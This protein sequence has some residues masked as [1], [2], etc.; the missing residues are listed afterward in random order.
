MFF[1]SVFSVS[2]SNEIRLLTKGSCIYAAI[3]QHILFLS[4][5]TWVL[6]KNV[7]SKECGCL[8]CNMNVI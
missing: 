5:G 6:I 3:H 2:Y 1:P 7:L 8:D 4:L